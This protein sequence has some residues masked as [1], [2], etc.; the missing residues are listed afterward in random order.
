MN[1]YALRA[2]Y[3]VLCGAVGL[4]SGLLMGRGEADPW[5]GIVL[6]L[7]FGGASLLLQ[8]GL[9]KAAPRAIVSG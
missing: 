2:V 4:A 7:A 9:R 3:V 1:E 5:K 8:V 6:G